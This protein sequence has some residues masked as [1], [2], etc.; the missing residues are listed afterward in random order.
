MNQLLLNM[1]VK[2]VKNGLDVDSIKNE[3]YKQAVKLELG[4]TS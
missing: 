2:Q 1:L 4:I 3:E